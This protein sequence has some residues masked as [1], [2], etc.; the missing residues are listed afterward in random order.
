MDAGI[1]LQE[2]KSP[3]REDQFQRIIQ[4][5]DFFEKL[6]TD[7]EITCVS[8]EKL[9]F[10]SFN[11]NNAEFVYAIRGALMMLFL[12]NSLPVQEYTPIEVKKYITGNGKAD[13]MLVQKTIMR[14]FKLADLPKFNDVA[15]ALGLAYL[16]KIR[17]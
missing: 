6:I 3:T 10:T 14:F 11:Q 7:Y 12:K 9:F 13:K 8:M 15:D 1:L 4:I 16:A 17:K 5:Y 2:K